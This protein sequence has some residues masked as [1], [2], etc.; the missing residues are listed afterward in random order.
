VGTLVEGISRLLMLVK[1][2]QVKPA[3]SLNLLQVF[4]DKLLSVALPLRLSMTRA[5]RWRG[6]KN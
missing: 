4:T 5:A 3:S 6:T 1:L 2:P